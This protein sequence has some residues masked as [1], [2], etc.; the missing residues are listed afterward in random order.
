M[1]KQTVKA[2]SNIADYSADQRQDYLLMIG[3]VAASDGQIHPTELALLKTWMEFF[4]LDENRRKTILESIRQSTTNI[5][6][7]EKRLAETDFVFSLILDM[8]GMAMADGILMD[9]EIF[10]LQKVAQNLKLKRTDFQILIEFVH[11]AHQASRLNN[12]EP[13]YEHSIESAFELM[14]MRN[15]RLFPHTLLCPTSK[16][17]DQQLKTRWS[18]YNH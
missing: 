18:N 5:T 1:G 15:V 14:R 10:L 17:F 2:F 3:A 6:E 13:L 9:D 4:Q 11:A 12:P 16:D 8:M 7:L